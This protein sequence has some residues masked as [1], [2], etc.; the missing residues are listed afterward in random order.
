[1]KQLGLSQEL[2]ID[3][4]AGGG[5]ASLGLEMATGHPVHIA[6]NHDP[7][8]IAMHEANHPYTKHYCESVWEVDPKEL[9]AGRPVGLVHLSPDCTHHSKARGGKPVKKS[10]RGLA[11]IALKWAGTVS[12]RII[13]LENVE[14]FR[15]WCP[16]V[17]KRCK[18]TKRV[19]KQDGTVAAPGKSVPYNE[20][21][22]VPCPKRKGESFNKLVN[23][24]RSM[25][26]K[27]E[28]KELKACDYGSPTSRKRFF[29]I[30]RRDGQPI[31]WPKPTHGN[32]KGL[33]PFRTVAECIDF[34]EPGKSIFGRKKPLAQNT[35][36]RIAAGF[37]K[38]ILDHPNPFIVRIGHTGMKT[39]KSY[40][41]N[42]PLT[43]I[44]TKNE[45]LV[46]SSFL[47][48]FR[49]NCIGH[50]LNEP[51]GTITAGGGH[52]AEVRA[53]MMKYYGT[54]GD[55][56]LREPC[57][58]ITTKDRFGLV[59][60][61]GEAHIVTDI[62]MRMLSPRELYKCQGFPDDYIIDPR[63]NGK[64]LTQQAQVR[65]C[66]NSVPPQVIAAIVKANMAETSIYEPELQEAV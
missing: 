50:H 3:N 35:L 42:D 66:G 36:D 33:K 16:V 32:S 2:I 18:K 31:V 44:C 38:Y 27:V 40:S 43:T 23:G 20:Q 62:T 15:N 9:C 58:T 1:M 45:H 61:K 21:M 12:P 11:Y 6:I 65:M 55:F 39:D 8:A 13:T 7:E 41:V 47:T 49:K 57:H 5:G 60:F 24:L 37:K 17:A 53:F 30:A 59:M 34:T 10:I 19:L 64:K 26:Y 51:V 28:W 25:G 46:V 54:G 52:F 14:E 4:F 48:K 56:D 63:V 22:L 29:L